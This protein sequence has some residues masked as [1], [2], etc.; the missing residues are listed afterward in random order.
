MAAVSK[1]QLISFLW[2]PIT[3]AI[4]ARYKLI[5]AFTQLPERQPPAKSRLT[6]VK[7]EKGGRELMEGVGRVMEI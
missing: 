6:V 4:Q 1:I 7:E 5:D 2:D 3:M